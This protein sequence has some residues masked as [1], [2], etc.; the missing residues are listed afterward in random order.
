VLHKDISIIFY[1][2]YFVFKIWDPL[3]VL[4]RIS[5]NKLRGYCTGNV[6]DYFFL[7]RQCFYFSFFFASGAN[8][9]QL[10]ICERNFI[11]T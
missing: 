10:S 9:L 6:C 4:S 8:K 1:S 2:F 7:A 5:K 3:K 11:L